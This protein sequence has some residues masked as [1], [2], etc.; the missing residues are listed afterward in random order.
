MKL[1]NYGGVV[2]IFL[3]LFGTAVCEIQLGR[4]HAVPV[5]Y[6]RGSHYEVGFDVGRT[7][8]SVIK[9]FISNY[10][11][12][13][14]FEREYKTDTGRDA[15]DKTLANMEKRFP[16][17][18]KEIRGV[19]DG[20]NV[21][22][23]QLFLLQM[24][25]LIG[26]INDNHVPRNDTGGC[27]SVAFKNPQHTIL[28]HTEDAFTE[29]LNH[30]YIMSAHIIPTPEDREH[31]AVE[32]RFSSLCY[33]G[34]MPGYTMGYN[35]NGMVFSINT[36][37][38]LLLKPGNTPRTFITRKLLSAKSFPDAERILRDE[39]LGIGN[40]FS[41]NMIWTDTWGDTKLYN[42]EVAPDLKGDR[43]LV[44]VQKYD[45]DTLVHCNIYNRINVIEVIGEIVG[46]SKSRLKAIHAHAAPKTRGDI[47]EILS[48]VTGKDFQVFSMQKDAI[49]KTIAAGIF[50]VEKRTWSIYIDKPSISEPVAVLPIRFS[51]L[52]SNK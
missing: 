37:S 30:F 6:V 41:V 36:L 13:R 38:P 23:Y 20:A 39:G 26:T 4:R 52:E 9:S 2:A 22:F 27:S 34:H 25:D 18:V 14:D 32:E 12:L 47:A 35:E 17:Y 21:P 42:V 49:I 24:D 5:I 48:D 50:D 8:S 3:S 16:Y 15:Y 44:H 28:G 33:A 31:G 10:A 51:E 46:S 45:Q 11:N 43:S 40:G 19:A 29:T 1:L 7:F